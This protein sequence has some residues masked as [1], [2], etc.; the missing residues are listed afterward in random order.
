MSTSGVGGVQQQQ[1]QQYGSSV[2]KNTVSSTHSVN[3]ESRKSG[4]F[5]NSG[6]GAGT[7]TAMSANPAF[8]MNN[9]FCSKRMRFAVDEDL[10]DGAGSVQSQ[11]SASSLF[12]DDGDEGSVTS[13]KHGTKGNNTNQTAAS[14][15]YSTTTDISSVT[16]GALGGGGANKRMM[17]PTP[18]LDAELDLEA[19]ERRCL[20]EAALSGGSTGSYENL[21]SSPNQRQLPRYADHVLALRILVECLVKLNRLD[22]IERVLTDGMEREIR[23]IAQREQARTLLRMERQQTLHRTTSSGPRGLTIRRRQHDLKDVRRHLM[24]L[25]SAFGCVMI[26]L[27]HLAQILRHRIVSND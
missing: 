13:G 15:N 8:G 11:G 24:G 2:N 25:L 22:D 5:S 17:I 6:V 9:P 27:S 3:S 18:L 23:R 12:S 21:F 10:N 14:S 19:D 4:I 7:Y 1:Q 26:R 16:S 20:E